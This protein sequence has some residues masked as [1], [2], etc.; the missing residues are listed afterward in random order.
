[1][2]NTQFVNQGSAV[3]EIKTRK[4]KQSRWIDK[5]YPEASD[6]T[7]HK[8]DMGALPFT[9]HNSLMQQNIRNITLGWI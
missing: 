2:H 8:K 5:G 1:M 9:K 6:A 7:K 4:V 3:S